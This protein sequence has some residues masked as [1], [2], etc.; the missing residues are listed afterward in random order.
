VGFKR[1]PPFAASL[2]ALALLSLAYWLLPIEGQVVILPGDE[3]SLPA[4]RFRLDPPAPRPGDEV[5]VTVTDTEPWSFVQLTV[6]G[7]PAHPLE[8]EP[9]GEGAW[10]WQW[11]FPAPDEPGYPIVFYHDCHTGCLERGRIAVGDPPGPRSPASVPTKLGVVF[12]DLERDWHGR[13]GWVVEVTYARR[14]E[15][16]YWG[17]DD[18][19]ARV[20]AHTRKG[21]RVIVRVD[22]DEGQSVPPAGDYLALTEYLDYLGRLARDERLA[23]VYGYVIGTGFNAADANALAPEHPVT[24]EWYARVFN[25]YGED[26]L[27]T[28]NAVQVIHGENARARVI[29]GPVRAWNEDQDGALA[30]A[31]DAPWLN[32]MYTLVACLDEGA[33]AKAEA[34]VPLVGP[35]GFDVQAPGRPDLAAE[36]LGRPRAD[37]PRL[38]LTREE[39][40]GARAGFRVYEDWLRIINAYPTTRGLPV[41]VISTNTYDREAGVPPAQNYPGGWLTTALEVVNEEPQIK[42]LCWFL[43]DFPHDEQWEWFSLSEGTGRLVD[44]AEEFDALLRGQ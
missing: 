14:S 3:G 41:Y 27:H 33:R 44:A 4:P 35:D 43:D 26:P 19:A 22:Y 21:L 6:D 8:G 1:V 34:G 10:S 2:G 36:M 40:G 20:A 38:D 13:A 32:Y 28:D 15:A 16:L 18:L 39:W 31:V 30:Y 7:A 9:A 24:P 12:P 29:V 42:A 11:L 23:D 17:V 5:V 37:E 25:G